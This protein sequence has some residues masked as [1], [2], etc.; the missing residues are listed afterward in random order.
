MGERNC[1]RVT[2][3]AERWDCSP[4]KIRDMI[5]TGA[6]PCLKLGKLVRIPVAAVYEFEAKCQNQT[7]PASAELPEEPRGTSISGGVGN[8]RPPAPSLCPRD[9]VWHYAATPIE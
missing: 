7:P 8:P 9:K 6:L 2:S 1:F 3:L 5:R 4:G